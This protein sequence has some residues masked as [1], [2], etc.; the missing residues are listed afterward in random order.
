MRY[1]IPFVVVALFAVAAGATELADGPIPSE[2]LIWLAG[3]WQSVGGEPGSGEQWT[4]PA[5]DTLLGVSRTVRGG[6]TVAYEFLR[7][8]RLDDG[9]LAYVAL[10]SGQRETTFPLLRATE[11]SLV[12]ENLEHDFPQR[13][14]YSLDDDGVLHARIEGLR[15]GELRSVDFPLRRIDC[16]ASAEV[17]AASE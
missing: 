17:R 11:R 12:F 16:E 13:V 4:P 2:G 15:R 1:P 5:G 9:R 3:C 10:P 14:I 8:R 6:R 7:I